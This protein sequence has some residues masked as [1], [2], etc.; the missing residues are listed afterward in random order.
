MSSKIVIK[1]RSA[2]AV[3][4]V[5]AALASVSPAKA[6]QSGVK[7]II[8]YTE[9]KNPEKFTRYYVDTHMPMVDKAPGV[10]RSEMAIVLPAPPG[11]PKPAFWRITEVY[12]DGAE[13]M[14]KTFATP[15]WKTITADVQN[16]ADPGT[17][18]FFVAQ[19]GGLVGR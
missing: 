17:V 8:L 11:Q 5:G 3:F 7:L 2:L 4:A 6:R 12:W 14:Q 15:E 18:S 1:R 10:A 19:I 13:S 9:Q 16:F